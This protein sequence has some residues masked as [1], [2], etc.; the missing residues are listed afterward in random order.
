MLNEVIDVGSV[1]DVAQAPGISEDGPD[2]P[3]SIFA[4]TGV[5]RQSTCHARPG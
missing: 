5:A 3:K 1:P 2:P 4:K